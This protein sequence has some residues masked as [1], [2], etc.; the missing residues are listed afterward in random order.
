MVVVLLKALQVGYIPVQL[1]AGA[2]GAAGVLPPGAALHG[3]TWGGIP[4][5]P[6]ATPS[7][8]PFASC[9]L[10][11]RQVT[12]ATLTMRATLSYL[13]VINSMMREL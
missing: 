2:D 12:M 13:R 5:S 11:P 7:L 4:P 1:L 9:P 10:Y 8:S 3:E 6:A